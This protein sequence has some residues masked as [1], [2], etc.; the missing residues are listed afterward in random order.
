[1]RTGA[2]MSSSPATSTGDLLRERQ[3][4]SPG[5]HLPEV[6]VGGGGLTAV[7]APGGG[8]R[9]LDERP[10]GAL[11]LGQQLVDPLPR[12]DVVRQRDAAEARAVRR[13]RRILGELVPRVESKRGCFALEQEAGPV[14]VLL[15]NRPPKTLGVERSRPLQVSDAERDDGDVRLHPPRVSPMTWRAIAA[16]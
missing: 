10:P 12:A 4:R 1:M 3:P 14:V 11:G 16:K 9:R 7:A 8:S 5:R 13:H 6:A 15:L 2:R